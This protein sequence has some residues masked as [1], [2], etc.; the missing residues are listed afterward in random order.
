MRW[1][2]NPSMSAARSSTGRSVRNVTCALGATSSSG[3]QLERSP[4]AARRLASETPLA[5]G[6]AARRARIVAG[7]QHSTNSSG[8]ARVERCG[9]RVAVR[10]APEA[11]V[12]DG[13]AARR[14][15][16]GRPAAELGR[17]EGV[18]VG[19]A[20]RARGREVGE[21][22]ADEIGAQMRESRERGQ[23]LGQ[24][25][26]PAARDAAHDDRQR[27]PCLPGKALGER[28]EVTRLRAVMTVRGTL[29]GLLG[30]AQQRHLR[31]HQ[32]TMRRGEGDQRI[33]TRVPTAVAVTAYERLRVALTSA[34]DQIHDQR[35]EVI[36]D[37]ELAQSAVEGHA[38]D[39][40]HVAV[41]QHVLGAQV[42]MP[43]PYP[44]A[45]RAGVQRPRVRH[46]ERVREALQARARARSRPAARRSPAAHG[47]SRPSAAR[48]PTPAPRPTPHDARARETPP[49]RSPPRA[50]RRA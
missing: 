21:P 42:A 46:D 26:L 10:A 50:P 8:A 39:Q 30:S 3:S 19:V 40:L 34:R 29:T 24:A 16:A 31:P 44:A 28:Q 35:R 27:Q 38:V 5:S 1:S 14:D 37:V 49:A 9:E 33:V 32:R 6:L 15:L 4:A 7:A 41:E 22:R 17:G 13:P 43:L 20:R 48:R 47:S 11:R 36:G 45:S 23:H 2:S 25:R 18:E 12:D